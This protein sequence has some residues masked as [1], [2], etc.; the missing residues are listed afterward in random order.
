MMS[1]ITFVALAS[2]MWVGCLLPWSSC[3]TGMDMRI[4]EE[5]SQ[6]IYGRS[7][8]ELSAAMSTGSSQPASARPKQL[9]EDVEL[10]SWVRYGLEHN[11]SLKATFDRWRASTERVAQAEALPDPI[12]TFF[13]FV[14]ELQTRTGPQKR[15]YGLSQALPWFGK[16]GLSGDV[17]MQD[18]EVLWQ[19]VLQRRLEIETEIRTA[20][21]EYG[22]LGELIRITRENL[23]LLKQLESVVQRQIQAGR[24]QEDLLRLQVEIGKLENDLLS[25][26]RRRPMISSRLAL[27]VHWRGEELLPMPRLTEPDPAIA[28]V[29]RKGLLGQVEQRNPR[30]QALREKVLRERKAADL[31]DLAGAPDLVL[32]VEYMETGPALAPNTPDSGEDPYGFRISFNLPIQRSKYSAAARQANY[33]L[34]ASHSSLR[35]LS[36]KLRSEVENEIYLLD[37]AMRQVRLH[38]DTLLPRSRQSLNVTR[39]SYSAGRASLLDLIDSERALLAIETTYWRACRDTRQARNRLDLLLGG[40]LQPLTEDR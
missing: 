14:E 36:L 10:E 12:F 30:L 16:L 2:L 5:R 6:Q 38:K 8:V 37:D 39:T 28:D 19:V 15:R 31:A 33:A 1:R 17:A 21:H 24:G 7:E 9:F 27:A 35:E 26:E 32:G 18:A 23:E 40:K 34:S 20:Y 22:Y 11:S 4:V 13:Q 25:L 29:D 3:S